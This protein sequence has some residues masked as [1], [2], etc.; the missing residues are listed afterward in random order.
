MFCANLIASNILPKKNLKDR[1]MPLK[2]RYYSFS[3]E[4]HKRNNRASMIGFEDETE[5]ADND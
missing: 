4:T 5:T 3:V 2:Y 1:L